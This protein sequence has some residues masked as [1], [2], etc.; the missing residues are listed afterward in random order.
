MYYCYLY[1]T[2]ASVTTFI[3]KLLFSPQFSSMA[4]F[5]GLNPA[6][7]YHHWDYIYLSLHYI[8]VHCPLLA[9][10]TTVAV[11]LYGP[12][13]NCIFVSCNLYFEIVKILFLLPML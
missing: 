11:V 1:I 3:S 4:C 9:D 6:C 2:A 12:A 8:M 10:W 7:P 5:K 13:L